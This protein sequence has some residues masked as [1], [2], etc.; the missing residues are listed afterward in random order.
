[1]PKSI[2]AKASWAARVTSRPF[3][4]ELQ[5]DRAAIVLAGYSI[6]QARLLQA[7]DEAGDACGMY[8][9]QVTEHGHRMALRVRL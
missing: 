2:W 5:V 7:I 1:M 3:G 8:E 4:R 9:Q 6:Y